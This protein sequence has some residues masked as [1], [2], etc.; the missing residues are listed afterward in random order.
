MCVWWCVEQ[1][2]VVSK[3]FPGRLALLCRVA[4][5]GSVGCLAARWAPQ[6]TVNIVLLTSPALIVQ[7]PLLVLPWTEG[8]AS[9]SLLFLTGADREC[10]SRV[11]G[12]ED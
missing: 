4:G 5:E 12:M 3:R 7:W 9:S 10:C 8:F 6:A 2:R 1:S 11:E